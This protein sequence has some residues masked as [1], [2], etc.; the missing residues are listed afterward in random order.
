ML[1]SPSYLG[2]VSIC[3]Y[4]TGW[5]TRTHHGLVSVTGLGLGLGVPDLVQ[6]TDLLL[7][8]IYLISLSQ[9]IQGEKNTPQIS[10]RFCEAYTAQEILLS[11]YKIS[12]IEGRGIYYWFSQPLYMSQERFELTD[13]KMFWIANNINRR[14]WWIIRNSKRN[15]A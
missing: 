7:K 3:P 1:R 10:Q 2:F 9:L 14:L 4:F 8:L 12:L 5:K 11:G 13:V 15:T 6:I